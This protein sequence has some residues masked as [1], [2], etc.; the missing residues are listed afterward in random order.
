MGS[1]WIWWRRA[2]FDWDMG[3]SGGRKGVDLA[4]VAEGGWQKGSGSWRGREKGVGF[5]GVV[6]LC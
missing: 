2:E 5:S 4:G 3:A 6:R 1:G